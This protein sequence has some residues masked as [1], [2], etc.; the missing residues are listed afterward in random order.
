MVFVQ[1][2]Q[3][4][5]LCITCDQ[6]IF[7]FPAKKKKKTSPDRRLEYCEMEPLKKKHLVT[8]RKENR[9]IGVQIFPMNSIKLKYEKVPVIYVVFVID[10]FTFLAKVNICVKIFSVCNLHLMENSMFVKHVSYNKLN[11]YDSRKLM[12]SNSMSLNVKNLEYHSLDQ[13]VLQII[14]L[15]MISKSKLSRPQSCYEWQF[16]TTSGGT[17]MQNLYAKRLRRACTS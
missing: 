12:V 13:E 15:S 5:S 8:G 10:Y 3:I 4:S 11:L 6:A 9:Q 16:Q 7:F 14:S 17:R 2:Q 1:A